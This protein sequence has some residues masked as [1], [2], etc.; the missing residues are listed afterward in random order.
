MPELE[1][2]TFQKRQVAYKVRVS[3]ILNSSFAKDEFSAGHIKLNGIN[4][5][6]INIIGTL[7]Y[8]SEEQN[9]SS[10]VIDDASGK[11]SL[12]T[13]GN[14]N[15]FAKIDVGDFVLVIGKVREFN[16]E[17]YVMPEILRKIGIE[18]MNLRKIELENLK[19]TVDE[20]K[21]EELIAI[22]DND[23]IYSLIKNLDNG[24]GV[25]F[26]DII[27]NS[28]TGKAEAMISKLLENGDVFE[29]KPG[30]LKV[31]E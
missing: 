2:K 11:I 9:Y 27:K 18:W 25:S 5:S 8:K 12:K 13:F 14:S 10:S 7:V 16:N 30:K 29:I 21:S 17:K 1:Q 23:E 31:L 20:N 19:H 26:E 28:A 4:V 6:R 15:I 3:D 22:D 24:D